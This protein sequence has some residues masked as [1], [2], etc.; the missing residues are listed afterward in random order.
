MNFKS[1]DWT[2]PI[3]KKKFLS[4]DIKRNNHLKSLGIPYQEYFTKARANK[5]KK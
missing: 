1:A 4:Y 2:A 5:I 3:R